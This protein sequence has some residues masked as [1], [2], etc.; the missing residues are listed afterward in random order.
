MHFLIDENL[1][2]RLCGIA[3]RFGYESTHVAH[4]GWA[5][6]P[7]EQ[8]FQLLV[9]RSYILVTNNRADF[10]ALIGATDIHP[11]LVVIRENVR[12]PRQ[13]VYFR[14]V[15]RTLATRQDLINHIA[16]IDRE[17]RVSLIERPVL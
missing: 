3:H 12:R 6:I 13:L 5:G 8:L 4:R 7:D 14:A 11:G 2:P 16:F 15:L 1:S 17:R 10:E 9:A